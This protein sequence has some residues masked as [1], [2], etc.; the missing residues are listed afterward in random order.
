[1]SI[2]IYVYTVLSFSYILLSRLGAWGGEGREKERK[3]AD[4]NMMVDK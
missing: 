3:H 2:S 1:M 4:K